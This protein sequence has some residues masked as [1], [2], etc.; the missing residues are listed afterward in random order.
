V[1][2]T[3][4]T[5]LGNRGPMP[6]E[7]LRPTDR[8]RVIEDYDGVKQGTVGTVRAMD[9]QLGLI[10]A[11]MMRDDGRA[12]APA[13]MKLPADKVVVLL[14]SGDP[15]VTTL[16]ASKNTTLAG[17]RPRSSWPED[18]AAAALVAIAEI[19]AEPSHEIIAKAIADDFDLS[20]VTEAAL[21]SLARWASSRRDPDHPTVEVDLPSVQDTIT[22][23][24][25]TSDSAVNQ[26]V[27]QA[28]KLTAR[29]LQ[30]YLQAQAIKAPNS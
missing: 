21:P 10:E 30:T 25:Q 29:L 22:W 14:N 15:R 27:R 19:S 17:V 20:R 16:H 6:P 12:V 7:Q 26:N 18:E 23:L 5:E 28:L 8:V 2:L 3:Y 9:S 13:N 24:M 4:E 1:R 11:R